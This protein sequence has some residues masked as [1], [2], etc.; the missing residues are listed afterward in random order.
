[1]TQR[2]CRAFA[3]S[4][5]SQGGS[6]KQDGI[7]DAALVNSLCQKLFLTKAARETDDNLAF[8]RT[9][10]L[11]SEAG[12]AALLDLYGRVR[13]GKRVRNDETNALCAVLRLSG[14]VKAAGSI[15]RLR[16]EV[17]SRVFDAAWIAEHMPDA[18]VRRQ[19]RAYR[20]GVLR[21]AA[22]SSVLLLIMAGLAGSAW[23]QS[24]NAVRSAGRALEQE[25]LANSRLSHFYVDAGLRMMDAQNYGGALAPFV[26]AMR[27]DQKDATRMEAATASGSS[28]PGRS[29]PAWSRCGLPIARFARQRS[30]RTSAGWPS[31]GENGD[32]HV[33]N[34]I[35]GKAL[36]LAMR[37]EAR[38]NFLAFHPSLARLATCGNDNK[39]RIW[40]LQTL[41]LRETL[42]LKCPP[43]HPS[44]VASVA[45]NRNGKRMVVVG[46]SR[47]AVWDFE[48]NPDGTSRLVTGATLTGAMLESAAL[49]D[50]GQNVAYV[51]DNYIAGQSKIFGKGDATLGE[52]EAAQTL[53]FS[54]YHIEYSPD[55][56]H[57]LVAG[58]FDGGGSRGGAGIY[59]AI[60]DFAHKPS[61]TWERLLPH[62]DNGVFATYSPDGTRI[63]TAS[64]DHTARVWNA[65]DGKP[66]TPPL[67]H[68]GV[69]NHAAF[70][71]D[72][73]WIV[74]ASAD[75]KAQVWNART[76][77]KAGSAM[78]HAGS[79]IFVAFGQD[80]L[81]VLTAGQDG[82]AR[83]WHLPNPNAGS[84]EQ[85][86]SYSNG[87]R[88]L[89]ATH[90]ILYEYLTKNTV[91]KMHN[92]VR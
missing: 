53:C 81:H 42:D 69:V 34:T 11:H 79:V 1:M 13:R 38:I 21:T 83:L 39:V 31:G 52:K 32:V 10:L 49:F 46:W 62:E 33:W 40:D 86:S 18:E 80:N 66:L 15:L 12:R 7:E 56:K 23:Q 75:G 61:T 64:R 20:L 67:L 44:N 57:L 65:R 17:Y 55:S 4:L 72:G 51:A 45:W 30:A 92:L 87:A 63:V 28:R 78:R 54:A 70:S 14:V 41:R 9:R 27:L 76:G 58:A 37:H 77:E 2:L 43:D 22:V 29:R 71:R 5:V 84:L 48:A 85:V 73:N 91:R 47:L 24:K 90:L 88:F 68:G 19:K 25:Q 60:H 26:E 6:G 8:V 16:N 36:P 59:T 50:D 35:T 89:D 3:E 82:T 74:T